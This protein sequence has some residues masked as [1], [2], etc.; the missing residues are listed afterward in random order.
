MFE[1]EQ[2]FQAE[3]YSPYQFAQTINAFYQ[4]VGIDRTM[5]AQMIYQYTQEDKKYIP[6]INDAYGQP[7]RKI[8]KAAALVWFRKYLL[9]NKIV[10]S[11]PA[12]QQLDL[13]EV[14]GDLTVLG[15]EETGEDLDTLEIGELQ[16]A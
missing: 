5:K 1:L 7:G 6:V 13:D 12:V 9:D 8:S 14:L 16:E 10:E 3:A 4:K 11:A 15:T 2:Y